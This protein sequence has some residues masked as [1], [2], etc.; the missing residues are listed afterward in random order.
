MT[1]EII[2]III[3][4]AVCGLVGGIIGSLF[5]LRN[6]TGNEKNYNSPTKR[7]S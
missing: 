3:I 2:R 5:Q 4:A 7:R 1:S 6:R